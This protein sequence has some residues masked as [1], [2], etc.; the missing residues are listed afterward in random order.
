[1]VAV[2]G[3]DPHRFRARFRARAREARRV[4][5]ERVLRTPAG[6]GWSPRPVAASHLG[7]RFQ[8]TGP[9]RSRGRSERAWTGTGGQGNA[10]GSGC[11]SALGREVLPASGIR[12]L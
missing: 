1:M 4:R 7:E 12:V 3:W 11:I 9:M 6:G 5:G 10:S 8:R 2:M